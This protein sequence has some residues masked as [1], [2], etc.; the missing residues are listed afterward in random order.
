MRETA[1]FFSFFFRKSRTFRSSASMPAKFWFD[2]YQREAQLRVTGRRKTS[3]MNFLSH[4]LP[5]AFSCRRSTKMWQ[6]GLLMRLPRPLARAALK[7]FSV[8]PLLDVDRGDLQLVDV[9]AVVVL[10]VGDGRLQHLLDDA[11]AFLA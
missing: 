1:A 4:G 5:S 8:A 3:R 6:V 9:G 11:G 7:R 2:A 10:G